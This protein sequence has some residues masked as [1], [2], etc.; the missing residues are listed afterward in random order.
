MSR[1]HYHGTKESTKID[2]KLYFRILNFTWKYW[3]RL[4]IGIFFGMLVGGSLLFALMMVPQMVSV[5]ENPLTGKNAAQTV[6]TADQGTTGD[7]QLDK[8]LG[9]V[10]D[11]SARFSLPVEVHGTEIRVTKPVEFAFHAASPDGTLAWQLL[12]LYGAGFAIAWLA[13]TIGEFLNKYFMNWVG[14]RVVADMRAYIFERLIAQSLRFY[15]KRDV[16][17]LIS[18]ATNDTSMMEHCVAQTVSELTCGPVQLLACLCAVWIACARAQTYSLL[19]I[20]LIGMGIMVLPMGILGS[21]IRRV[22]RQT[23]A[24]IAIVISRMHEVFTGIR[25]VKAY[26]SEEREAEMFR[27]VNNNYFKRQI[28]AVRLQLLVSPCTEFVAVVGTIVF[29]V[30]ACSQGTRLSDLAALLSPAFMAYKPLKELSKSFSYIQRS[31]AAADRYFAMVDTHTELPEKADG[32]VLTEFTGSIELKEVEF[33]YEDR[34]ILDKVS[35]SIPR[36]STVAIVGETGSGKSTIGNLV[37]RFYDVDAGAVLIDGVDVRDYSIESLRKTIGVV[38]QEAILFN[39]TIAENIAYGK[40]EASMAEIETAAKQANAHDFIVGGHH[41][42]GYQTNVGEKGFKLSGGEKQ[43]VSIAR[44]ILRNPPI[45]I[46]DEATSALDTVT[47]KQVQDALNRVMQ[48]RTVLAIAHR[49]STIRHAD[50]I[51][52]LRA[53]KIIESGTHEELLALNGVYRK[54]YETQFSREEEA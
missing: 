40:P 41:P 14:V 7:P 33:S 8:L 35:F 1:H 15:G 36:G 6:Q 42:E 52:V 10:R 38:T 29:L 49:L 28:R 5:V 32:K 37:A 30:F 50:K 18:R 53:G 2:L 31:M 47:E 45:L 51:I 19:V 4:T 44:A 12:A 9:Q 43:R 25:V 24:R 39:T 17:D 20:L 16:G 54:L 22:C 48:N 11:Y 46:L 23:F 34:K 13:K 26:H 21:M 27:K 3:F